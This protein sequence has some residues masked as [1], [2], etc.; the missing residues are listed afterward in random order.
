MASPE[1]DDALL[2][3]LYRLAKADR[4]NLP[5]AHLAEALVA[6]ANRMFAD[7]TAD[8]RALTQYFESLH[9]E[10][11]ALACACAAGDEA[12]WEH[13]I[14]EQRPNLYRAADHIDPSGGAREIADA[15]YAELYGLRERLGARDS[16]FRHYHGRSSLATWLRAVLAQRHVDRMRTHSRVQPLPDESSSAAF[17]VAAEPADPDR[18]RYLTLARHTLARA[19]S[20]LEARDRLRLGCYYTQQLTLAEIGRLFGEH[21]ATVSRQLARIRRAIRNDVEQQLRADEQLNDAQIAECFASVS[22]DPGPINLREMLD[23]GAER[24]ELVP[25]RS[26]RRTP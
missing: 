21:E 5:R 9:L 8:S 12:A 23:A 11:L 6:S 13:F 2:K 10:E 16:L 20:R 25:G 17:G 3:R 22:E 1:L 4:W 14:R 15:L 26:V 24:K 7:K 19:L 18:Q